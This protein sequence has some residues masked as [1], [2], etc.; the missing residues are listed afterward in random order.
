M[1]IINSR[2]I[3]ADARNRKY[4]IP[5]LLGGNLEMIIGQVRAA[6]ERESPL[7]LVFNQEVTPQ[8]PIE[9]GMPLIVNAAKNASV[10]VATI[11]DHGRSL[12]AIAEAIRLGTSSVMFDGSSLPYEENVKRTKEVVEIAHAAGICVEAELGSIVYNIPRKL[13][14]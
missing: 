12:G 10:P 4:G 3:L 5:G 14:C 9:L 2:E 1:P 6:E 11:L 7:T 8:I 13:L